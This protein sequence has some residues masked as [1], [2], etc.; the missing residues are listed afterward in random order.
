MLTRWQPFPNWANELNRVHKELNRMFERQN[1]QGG[2]KAFPP[3]NIW[4]DDNQ[5]V[6][7]AELPGMAMEDL[8]ILIDGENRLTLKGQRQQKQMESG[9]WHRRER[10][11]G[12]FRRSIDLPSVIDADRVEATLKHGLLTIVMPKRDE[13]KP[14]KIEVRG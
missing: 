6:I 14:R 3:M 7:E 4:Q 12:E 2:W 11:H 5:L 1:E 8:E 13:V 10:I 9:T